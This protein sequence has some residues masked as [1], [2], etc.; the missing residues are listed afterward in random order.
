M[1]SDRSKDLVKA[2]FGGTV[3]D[4]ANK[5]SGNFNVFIEDG[6]ISEVSGKSPRVEEGVLDATGLC[7]APGFVDL[8]THLR[9]PG[10]EYKED[11]E[12]GSRAAAAGG[13]TTV[14]CMPNT[15][16]ANDCALVTRRIKDR[17][18]E[19]GLVR[20]I[21]VGAMSKGLAGL[22]PADI[23]GMCEEGIAAIS[24]DGACIQDENLMRA[25]M[26][27]A[28]AK[29]LLVISHPEDLSISEDGV[30]N[31]GD[32]ARR[33]RLAG[34][35]RE[36]ENAIIGR[37]IELARETGARLHVAH[38]STKEGIGLVRRAKGDGIRI[39]CEVTP[40]HLTLT[41]EA[42]VELGPNAK[43]KPPLRT[44]PDRLALI[45]GLQ[46]GTVDAIATDHAPH[47]R[48]EKEDLV[49]A[50]FGVIGMETALPVCMKL[51]DEGFISLARLIELLTIGPARVAHLKAGTLSK[52][53]AADVAIFDSK[54]S[55]MIDVGEFQS[56]AINT[57][58]AGR[59]VSGRVIHTIAGG[60]I[61]WRRTS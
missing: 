44:E 32:V 12:S 60:R 21:P 8:H 59:Q 13:Y 36:A 31:E 4:P 3:I 27:I 30:I 25:V 57:P 7:V 58:F 26:E 11:I 39:T 29:D 51:V 28:C 19:L 40:H 41:E 56:K 17:A 50:E 43:M 6:K 16:P 9:E 33:L 14:L 10:F 1:K 20:V 54:G 61:V 22:E 37:D 45:E 24:D 55:Y 46:D 18:R 34:I 2:I 15:Y 48:E 23:E 38:I 35:P 47:S 5:K 52:G 53:V 42:V 49:G